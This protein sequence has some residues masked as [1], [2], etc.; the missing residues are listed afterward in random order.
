LSGERQPDVDQTNTSVIV[1]G[2]DAERDG[3]AAVVKW[4]RTP[5]PN[6]REWVL[7]KRLSDNGFAA[8]P[9]LYGRLRRVSDDATIATVSAFLPG[10]LDGWDWCVDDLRDHLTGDLPAPSWPREIGSLTAAMHAALAAEV[11]TSPVDSWV[12]DGHRRIDTAVRLAL[13]SEERVVREAGDVL[14]AVA[15]QLH[16]D[17]AAVPADLVVPVQ[18]CHG[19][20]H[21]GQLLRHGEPGQ[22]RIDVIDF[23]GDPAT[24]LDS[25][26]GLVPV[27]KDLAQL[28]VSLRLV[29]SI[30][31]RRRGFDPDV[32]RRADAWSSEAVAQL[33]TAYDSV[34]GTS[35]ELRTAMESVR[36]A[37]EIAYAAQFLPRWAYASAGVLTRRFGLTAVVKPDVNA[38]W[39]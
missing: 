33:M 39:D 38:R 30:V 25:R 26:G 6:D 23:E 11:T 8:T 3:R 21:V 2:P 20:L 28:C 4:L 12:Q 16:A 31:V 15:D 35:H 5:V 27:E 34:R 36:L 18:D 19:D 37:D 24:A 10:A 7:G 22:R 14:V 32:A 17:V 1:G 29:G 13:A 9:R